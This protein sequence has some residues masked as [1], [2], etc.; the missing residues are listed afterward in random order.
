[1]CGV[2]ALLGGRPRYDASFAGWTDDFDARLPGILGH[3]LRGMRFIGW[4]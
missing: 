1:V 4:G 2:L 3:P